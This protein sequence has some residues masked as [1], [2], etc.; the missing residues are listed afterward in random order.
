MQTQFRIALDTIKDVDLVR[1]LD[2]LNQKQRGL[3]I[4]SLLRSHMAGDRDTISD[5]LDKIYDKLV[6]IER[7]G[8]YVPSEQ[9]FIPENRTQIEHSLNISTEDVKQMSRN[10]DKLLGL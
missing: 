10:L 1:F 4:K 9:V 5:K 7:S 6:N 2:S 8:T 3:L